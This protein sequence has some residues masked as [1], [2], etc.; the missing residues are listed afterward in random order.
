MTIAKSQ[1]AEICPD[2]SGQTLRVAV[3]YWGQ[4][5]KNIYSTLPTSVCVHVTVLL[6]QSFDLSREHCF[7]FSSLSEHTQGNHFKRRKAYSFRILVPGHRGNCLPHR[8]Q[9]S[10]WGGTWD[11]IV[12]EGHAHASGDL[13]PQVGPKCHI[14]HYPSEYI[15][16]LTC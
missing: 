5:H 10:V 12:I 3:I 6:G 2:P 11:I 4:R 7:Q 1:E 9:D 13:F 14:F 16:V 15:S 8:G